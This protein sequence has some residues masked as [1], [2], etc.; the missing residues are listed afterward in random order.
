MKTTTKI[1]I[2]IIVFAYIALTYAVIIIDKLL[3]NQCELCGK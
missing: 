2:A 1:A 3:H